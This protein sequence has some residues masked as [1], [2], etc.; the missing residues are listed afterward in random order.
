VPV[1]KASALAMPPA[2]AAMAPPPAPA[3]PVMPQKPAAP[4]TKAAAANPGKTVI[5][6]EV[7]AYRP[8]TDDCGPQ[9]PLPQRPGSSPERK[10]SNVW[11]KCRAHWMDVYKKGIN[12][13][14]RDAN[15]QG[16]PLQTVNGGAAV[17]NAYEKAQGEFDAQK[18]MIKP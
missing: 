2:R 7:A 10:Q 4:P 8:P 18:A 3:K 13:L 1:P 14:G 16:A 6:A 9:P 17:I 12:V 5:A 11:L 15:K